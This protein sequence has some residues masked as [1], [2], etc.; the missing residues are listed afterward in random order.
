VMLAVKVYRLTALAPVY[1]GDNQLKMFH[2]YPP[3]HV[4]KLDDVL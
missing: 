1:N 3:L 4:V 2:R